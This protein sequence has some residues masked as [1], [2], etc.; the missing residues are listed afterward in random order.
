M[1]LRVKK[2][3]RI[4]GKESSNEDASSKQLKIGDIGR[5]ISDGDMSL[6]LNM[7]SGNGVLEAA[8]P[9][10]K[11]YDYRGKWKDAI[12]LLLY[13]LG[14][15]NN[16]NERTI[17][18]LEDMVANFVRQIGDEAVSIARRP[19]STVVTPELLA[20]SEADRPLTIPRPLLA[21]IGSTQETG[22]GSGSTGG[23]G[24]GGGQA[25]G[26]AG[27]GA[28]RPRVSSIP[29]SMTA[30]A[31]SAAKPAKPA[32]EVRE[33]HLLFL[34]RNNPSWHMRMKEL[35]RMDEA[36]RKVNEYSN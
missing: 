35:I 19:V 26:A 9:M 20:A 24:G 36:I 23:L 5:D 18:L 14:E 7:D 8:P 17:D 2:K 16:P 29:S 25:A 22:S 21:I 30:L 11:T 6:R 4:A 12:K 1:V 33:E 3:V 32:V 13:S 28:T 27:D 31:P 15:D 10:V 34:T